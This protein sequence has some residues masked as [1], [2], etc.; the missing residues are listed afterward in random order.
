MC[1]A[2]RRGGT[3]Q[4]VV[5]LSAGETLIVLGEAASGKDA[6]LR[7][8]DGHSTRGGEL[9]GA[10]GYGDGA[11][12]P[13]A[14]RAKPAIRIVYLAG[15]A[16]APLNPYSSVASQLSRVL[17]SRH[18]SPL[19]SA[20]EEL[21]LALERFVQAPAFATLS[22]KPGE[23]S[24]MDMTWALLAAAMAQAPDLLIAD[25]ALADLT[26]TEIQ[27]IVAA[28]TTEQKRLGFALIYA[29]RDLKTAAHL[30]GRMIVL[31][32]GRIIEEGQFDKLAS[33]QSH[34][35]TRTLFK[36]LP[37]PADAPPP[38]SGTR[39]EPLLQVQALDLRGPKDR[40]RACVTEFPSSSG[41]VLRWR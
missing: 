17:A 15:A 32:Q 23:I 30:K 33:G 38:R 20:A 24:A 34:A 19:Q 37:R 6:L 21:R 26:P 29:A 13:A 16:E 40:G 39:G 41:A 36:A 3:R 10:I 2:G 31:R 28:L 22:K 14:K 35:Y 5:L 11:A 18:G 4:T 1:R 8:L 7:A 9:S 25:H 27:T 12:A